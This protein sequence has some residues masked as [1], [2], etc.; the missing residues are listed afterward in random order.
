[1]YRIIVVEDD[2]VVDWWYSPKIDFNIPEGRVR[3]DVV[4][5]VILKDYP[6]WLPPDPHVIIKGTY[7]DHLS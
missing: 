1:M 7:Q 3:S 2:L 6:Y 5:H 4:S